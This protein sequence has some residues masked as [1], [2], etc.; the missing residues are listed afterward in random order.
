[1]KVALI[2]TS[3]GSHGGGE[4]YLRELALGLTALG[5]NTTI[6]FSCHDQMQTL[7]DSCQSRGLKVQRFRYRNTYHRRCRSFGAALD[8]PFQRNFSQQLEGSGADILHINQQCLEDGLDLINAAARCSLPSVSTIHVTRTAR[9]MGARLAILRDGLSRFVLRKS[10]LPLIGIS[11]TSAEYLCEFLNGHRNL[12]RFIDHDS[13]DSSVGLI[14]VYSVL[15]GVA[16]PELRPREELRRALGLASAHVVIG[17]IAR[18]EEQK[19]P[20]FFC[21]LLGSLPQHVHCVWIGDGRLRTQLEQEI[22]RCKL[23]GR[24]HLCGWQEDASS[25]LSAFDIFSLGSL[26]EG[27]P[28]AL[29]EA[30]AASLPCVVSRVDGTQDAIHHGV[31]GFLCPVNDVGAWASALMPLIELPDLRSRIGMAARRRYE[32][33]F[34][35]DAMARR[36]LAVYERVMET[37][38]ARGDERA[39]RRPG[40]S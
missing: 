13:I 8:L 40:W 9:S 29:L 24:F 26:Y 2:S 11:A 3:S 36:T 34:S 28:L 1:M 32:A 27:L 35:L 33:E 12:T 19:N 18:I 21:R 10:G 22:E 17:V 6:W 31:D 7:A 20:M 5:H 25:W 14:P 16:A 15:N 37:R 39:G 30:A 4:F 38:A 23:T